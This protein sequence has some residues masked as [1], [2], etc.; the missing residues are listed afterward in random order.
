MNKKKLLFEWVGGNS[1]RLAE[2]QPISMMTEG[3]N[4]LTSSERT[5]IQAAFKK[6]G[7]DGNGRFE[8]KE[9]GLAAVTKILSV[10]GFQLDMVTG[11]L[12]MGDKGYRNFTFRRAN[13][14]DQD[15]FTEKPEI[16]NSY[17]VFNWER[18]DGPTHQ[19][20]DSPSKFEIHAYA[21]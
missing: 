4:T 17:I 14:P 18:M 8:K 6:V 15:P 16:S 1:F 2:V 11:D 5:K 9:L 19:H 20:P 3:G 21:S 13:D 7:L 12:I 10:L